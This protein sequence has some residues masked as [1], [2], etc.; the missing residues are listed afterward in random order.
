MMC[1]RSEAG[2]AG[3]G[4]TWV[5]LVLVTQVTPLKSES[6]YLWVRNR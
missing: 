5:S 6:A 4:L 3:V 1:V 2:L